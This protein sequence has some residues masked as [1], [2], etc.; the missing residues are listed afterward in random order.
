[1]LAVIRELH[2]RGELTKAQQLLLATTKPEEELYD[3]EADP[4]ELKNL[5]QSQQHQQTL[6]ELR[7]LLDEWIAETEDKGLAK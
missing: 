7:A 6:E 5:A 1:M 2:S 3:L 4:H